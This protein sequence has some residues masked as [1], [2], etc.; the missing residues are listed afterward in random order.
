MTR[1]AYLTDAGWFGLVAAG[2]AFSEIPRQY[3]AI[4][5]GFLVFSVISI[6][7]AIENDL[8]NHTHGSDGEAQING[9]RGW[10]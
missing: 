3:L 9:I 4:P 2:L 6:D 5:I 7:T 8:R 1:A 10:Y